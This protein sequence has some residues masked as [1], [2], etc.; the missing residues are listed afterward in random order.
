MR[1]WT[2]KSGIRRGLHRRD[3][4]H[5]QRQPSGREKNLKLRSGLAPGRQ[6]HPPSR[7]S[8][9]AGHAKGRDFYLSIKSENSSINDFEKLCQRSRITSGFMALLESFPRRWRRCLI[10]KPDLFRRFIFFEGYTLEEA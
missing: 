9:L 1:E 6:H 2:A 3:Q 8:P 10:G 5:H 7:G 4:H